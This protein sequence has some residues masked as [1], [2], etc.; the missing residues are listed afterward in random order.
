MLISLPKGFSANG[1]HCGLKRKRRD[2]SIFYSGKPCKCSAIF[3]KNLVKAAPVI[4]CRKRIRK[5]KPV[6]AVI[7]NSANANCMTGERGLKDASKMIKSTAEALGV[8][9]SSVMVSSTGVIGKYLRMGPVIKGIK[10]L[11]KTLSTD[12]VI[13]AAEGIMTTDRFHKIACRSFKAGGKKIKM[14]GVAKGA[15]MIH[16]DMATMLCYIM[17]DADIDKKALDKALAAANGTSFSSIT[18]DG[19]MSTND[20]VFLLA[21]GAAANRTITASGR[22][23]KVFLE[24]LGE[25]MLDLAKMIV[26]DGEGA[27]KLIDIHVKGCKTVK[28]AKKA[29]MAIAGS[30]LTKCAVHGG[31][32][33]WGRVASSVG[34]SGVDFD[35]AKM[36][37]ILDDVVFLEKGKFL[38]PDERKLKTVFKGKTVNI[39]V[40]LH[41]G[42]ASA[43]A[44]S[45]DIS[46]KYIT[47]NSYYTT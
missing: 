19:D 44:Y 10:K 1:I 39:E 45:C 40:N 36:D 20:S 14:V 43:K 15:G 46:K 23:F 41:R 21:N 35:P 25:V 31:D 18:V 4:L 37:I 28:D 34:A 12:G 13:N 8:P 47:I 29:A 2:L 3:T 38:S 16:P 26:K 17:T 9:E 42:K 30:L 22:D 27:S 24:K 6:R 33:N 5:N 11:S 32:P 7:V